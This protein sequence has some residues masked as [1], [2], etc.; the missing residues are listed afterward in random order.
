MTRIILRLIMRLLVLIVGGVGM[1][2]YK[3]VPQR[4]VVLGVSFRHVS[5]GLMA[6]P[7]Q[8]EKYA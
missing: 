6:L 1:R 3:P 7:R 8:K 5:A 4:T 2:A